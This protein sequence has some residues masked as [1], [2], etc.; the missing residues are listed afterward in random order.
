[1]GKRPEEGDPL[2]ESEEQ[3][4]V[5]DGREAAADIGNQKDEKD[6]VESREAVSVHPDPGTDQ[7]HRGARGADEVGKHGAAEQKEKIPQ[8]GGLA[9]HA[10]MDATRHD[11][12]GGHQD[13]EASVFMQ[14]VPDP[15]SF[16]QS[17]EIVSCH[18]GAEHH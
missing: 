13:Q 18:H 17:N 5:S 1:M 6:G 3:W 12:E 11:E 15:G 8:R 7:E 10:E 2:Q 9:L 14:C 16:V 4:R